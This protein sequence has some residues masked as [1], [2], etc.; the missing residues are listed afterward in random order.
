MKNVLSFCLFFS[1]NMAFGEVIRSSIHSMEPS[2]REMPHIIK[3]SNG[4]VAFLEKQEQF[5]ARELLETSRRGDVVEVKVSEEQNLVSIQTIKDKVHLK[6]LRVMEEGVN[7]IYEP[8]IL[9]SYQ[10]A[11]KIFNSFNSGYQRSSECTNRA[12]IWSYEEFKKN[13]TKSMKAFIFF[14]NSYIVRNKFKWWFHVAPMFG[15]KHDGKVENFVFDYMFNHRPVTIKEWKDNFLFSKRDC[16]L[17]GTFTEYDQRAD[18][19]QDC[20]MMFRPMFYWMPGDFS[21]EEISNSKKSDFLM[22][23]IR[24][25]YSEAF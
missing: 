18:Q 19:G 3:F 9:G 23:D 7:A 4:R 13:G 15:V 5:L 22:G 8:T 10:E 1:G 2:R 20:Y 11:K 24:A 17:D 21:A 16:K 25:A 6:Q 12:H 14:T